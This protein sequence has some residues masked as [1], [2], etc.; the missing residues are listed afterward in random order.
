MRML[1]WSLAVLAVMAVP[2][3]GQGGVITGVVTDSLRQPLPGADVIARPGTHRARTDSLGRFRLSGMD[4]GTYVVVARKF[5]YAPDK[6]DVKL[7]K[8]GRLDVKFVLARRVQLDTVTVVGRR[9]CPAFS[10]EGFMCRRGSAGGVYLDFP[11]IDEA[12][13]QETADLFRGIKGFRVEFRST[14]AGLDRVAVLAS[15]SSCLRSLVNGRP[16]TP[17]NFIPRYAADLTAIEIYLKPDSVPAPYQRHTWPVEGGAA[18][19][20]AVVVYWTTWAAPTG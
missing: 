14:R 13:V 19:R 20:C 18:G 4:D 11:D 6:W 2:A 16:V 12:G 17:A 7:S 10:V 5:G 9:D 3:R 8:N 1:G 15:R